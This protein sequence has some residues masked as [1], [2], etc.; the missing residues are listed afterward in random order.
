MDALAGQVP[1]LLEALIRKLFTTEGHVAAPKVFVASAVPLVAS[2]FWHYSRTIVE[3][4]DDEQARWVQYWLTQRQDAIRRVRRVVLVTAGSMVGSRQR[5]RRHYFDEP[6]TN[7]DETEVGERFSPPKLVETPAAGVSTWIWFGWFPVSIQSSRMSSMNPYGV[8]RSSGG[9]QDDCR[10]SLTVWF[11]PRGVDIAK[12]IILEGRQLWLSKRSTKT[13]VLT[14]REHHRPIS[15][16]VSARPSR[17]LSSVIVEGNTKALLLEDATRFLQG[18][19]WYFGK[20]IPYRRGYLLYG[21]PGCGKTSLITALAGELR[22]PIVLVPLSGST[23][24]STIVEVMRA[25]PRDSIV[26]IE[27]V[28]C[29]LPEKRGDDAL[30]PGA[31][32]HKGQI[33]H[34]RPPGRQQGPNVTLSGLLNA[35]DG[36][37]AQEGRLLFMTTNHRNRLDEALIRPGRVDVQCHLQNA[38]RAAAGELFDQFFLTPGSETTTHKSSSVDNLSEA[39]AAFLAEVEDGVHSFAKLQGAL[40][41]ARDDPGRSAEEMRIT[42]ATTSTD[43]K[44]GNSD[45][46]GNNGETGTEQA[47]ENGE[48][49][50]NQLASQL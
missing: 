36:V 18:E 23:N 37:A 9:A 29:A 2:L 41:K 27:D 19:K 15:F 4:T 6:S 22:L 32:N 3:I 31:I 17:P 12:K 25:A 38:S 20:G 40:M 11:A 35:I 16:D 26:L 30:P 7:Q 21:P 1:K 48:Q 46:G 28:D 44:G 13:E 47:K 33:Y 50:S 14:F 43:D 39:R 45:Q 5:G 34:S 24:D 49:T 10:C 42:V 8:P